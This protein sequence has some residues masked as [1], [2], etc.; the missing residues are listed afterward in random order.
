[1]SHCNRYLSGP[2]VQCPEACSH[3]CNRPHHPHPV[4]EIVNGRHHFPRVSHKEGAAPQCLPWQSCTW[5]CSAPGTS[6]PGSPSHCLS[7][8]EKLSPLPRGPWRR[9]R[10]CWGWTPGGAACCPPARCC[11]ARAAGRWAWSDAHWDAW[12]GSAGWPLQRTAE[13]ASHIISS[14]WTKRWTASR[15]STFERTKQESE[16]HMPRSQLVHILAAWDSGLVTE[17]LCS[18]VSS[19]VKWANQVP[20]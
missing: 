12:W 16:G 13:T 1:M 2:E 7:A 4:L 18:S 15:S 6:P 20:H 10:G 5:G 17:V 11:A 8:P 14:D 9:P 3:L 19:S